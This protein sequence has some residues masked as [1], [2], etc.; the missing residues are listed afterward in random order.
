[1]ISP[2]F[3]LTEVI[4]LIDSYKLFIT[5]NHGKRTQGYN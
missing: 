4:P 3:R 2:D 1:M 5:Q